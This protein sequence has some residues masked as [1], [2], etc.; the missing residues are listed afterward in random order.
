MSGF[1]WILLGLGLLLLL[2]IWWSGR[3]GSSQA[4]GSPGFDAE[5]GGRMPPVLEPSAQTPL[6]VLHE[7]APP[8]R[9]P[10]VRPFEPLRVS[11]ADAPVEPGSVSIPVLAQPEDDSGILL[12]DDV[13]AFREAPA[14]DTLEVPVSDEVPA[15]M[16]VFETAELP[17]T[18]P[19]VPL[20]HPEA[21]D[22]SVPEPPVHSTP[23]PVP[24]PHLASG[25]FARREPR[26][27]PRTD[28]SGRFSRVKAEPPRPIE[29]QK[30]VTVRVHAMG[31]GGWSGEDV[32]TALAGSDLLHGRYGVFHRLHPDGRTVFFVASL[33]EPG[34]FDPERMHEQRFPGLSIFAVLPG[35]LAPVQALE[36]LL[37]CARQLSADLSGMMQDEQGNPL[38]PQR[39][40]L[41]REEIH[42]F[43]QQ[44]QGTDSP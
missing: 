27:A 43:E 1:R 15:E 16:P 12:L 41:L 22:P 10:A 30:I 11:A 20:E 44:L 31:E 36:D 33:I 38:S 25:R 35:P 3:R 13:Q 7:P 28:T 5:A 29:L 40:G 17:F 39:I 32:A 4:R 24:E 37:G 26:P 23:A 21:L 8:P 2:G 19:A 34:S 14:G 6:A 9:E 42:H 18:D